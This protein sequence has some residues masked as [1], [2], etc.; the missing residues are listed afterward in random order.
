MHL[1]LLYDQI[2]QIWAKLIY[3]LAVITIIILILLVMSEYW[4]S[5]LQNSIV[6][7]FLL[8]K[9]VF[10]QKRLRLHFLIKNVCICV[11]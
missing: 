4:Y 3:I 11:M 2:L 6:I 9:L 5:S 7:L 10:N 8:F 1:N